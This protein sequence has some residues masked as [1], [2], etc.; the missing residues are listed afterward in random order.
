MHVT[1]DM[2]AVHVIQRF[3]LDLN[4]ALGPR[5]PNAAKNHLNHAPYPCM[6]LGPFDFKWRYGMGI[7]VTA[8]WALPSK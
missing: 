5:G 3:H 8:K 7:T 2:R 6:G 4:W 1:C